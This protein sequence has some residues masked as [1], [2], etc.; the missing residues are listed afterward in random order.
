MA[1]FAGWEMPLWYSSVGEEHRAVREAAGLFDVMHMGV[2]EME[3]PHATSFLDVVF[4]NHV[5]GLEV[6]QSA[7]GYLL[8]CD[9]EVIDDAIVYRRQH[10]LYLMVVNAANEARDWDWLQSV[11]KRSV[12]ID[13]SRPWVEIEGSV[14][15]RNLKDAQWG[16]NQRGDVALQ[17]PV[18]LSVL[19]TMADDAQLK[20]ELGQLRRNHLLEGTLAAIPVIIARTGYTGETWGFEI[21]VHPD[22]AP[23]LWTEILKTGAPLGVKP[24]GLAARDSLR[25]EAG[26]PLWGHELAG[27]FN[28]SPLEAGF[29][30]FV[31]FHKPFYVGRDPMLKHSTQRQRKVVRFQVNAKGKRRPQTG[32]PVIDARGQM[33]GQVTSCALGGDQRLVGLA[34]VNKNSSAPQTSLAV[35][36]LGGAPTS[37]SLVLDGRVVM[38][39]EVTVVSR[40][41]ET[42][43]ITPASH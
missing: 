33:V 6:G 10:E 28:V 21:F 14:T 38:Q 3:G 29:S 13:A 19:Q 40:F 17:G 23:R 37:V 32:D 35:L 41:P 25:T 26:L 5:G 9:G 11:N 16:K 31:K 7:Y 39:V 24:I 42:P 2:F 22:D 18:S 36:P 15:L 43:S 4:S 30:G 8:G 1:P 20:S 27:D 12:M 34:I